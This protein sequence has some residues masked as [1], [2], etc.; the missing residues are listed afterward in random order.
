M[1]GPEI[2]LTRD[3]VSEVMLLHGRKIKLIDTAGWF[4]VANA[5]LSR[6]CASGVFAEQDG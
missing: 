1:I 5:A 4:P 6:L 3:P 2:G